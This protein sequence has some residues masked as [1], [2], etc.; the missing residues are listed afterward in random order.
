M[1]PA[2]VCMTKLD[3]GPSTQPLASSARQAPMA[4]PQIAPSRNAREMF[5]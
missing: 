4:I 1:A 5:H 3:K 2:R